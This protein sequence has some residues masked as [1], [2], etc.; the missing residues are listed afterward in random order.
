MIWLTFTRYI[1]T[2][3]QD[4]LKSQKN[5]SWAPLIC[6]TIAQY[7][8]VGI[9]PHHFTFILSYG[10]TYADAFLIKINYLVPDQ[11]SAVLVTIFI[12]VDKLPG[13]AHGQ[14]IPFKI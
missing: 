1:D 14:L 13:L 9:Y 8:S 12:R 6:Q 3:L 4:N 10:A 5:K 11:G 2:I 7:H